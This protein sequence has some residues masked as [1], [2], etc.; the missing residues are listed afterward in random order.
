MMEIKILLSIK[1]EY[2]NKILSLEKRYEFRRRIWRKDV[3]QVLVYETLPV[4]AITIAFKIKNIIAAPPQ[5]LWNKYHEF[6]G[7]S[8]DKFFE[9]FQNCNTG[10]AIEIGNIKRFKPY[11]LNIKPPQ[12]YMYIHE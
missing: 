11:K 4:Q 2:V 1:P 12:S 8:Q 10:Y 3:K 7:I 9:Y 5:I 6:S